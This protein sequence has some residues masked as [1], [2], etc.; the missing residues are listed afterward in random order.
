[1]ILMYISR[2]QYTGKICY[3]YTM[4]SR[5]VFFFFFTPPP[6]VGFKMGGLDFCIDIERYVLYN[7]QQIYVNTC[8][9]IFALT[10]LHSTFCNKGP[11]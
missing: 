1:M 2:E 6:Q 5:L 9:T 11:L 8:L 4:N 3:I 10:H 7:Q